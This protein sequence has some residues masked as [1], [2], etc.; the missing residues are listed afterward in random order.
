LFWK[1]SK[2]YS[3]FE[4]ENKPAYWKKGTYDPVENMT[5][6]GIS[7]E[8]RSAKIYFSSYYFLSNGIVE[9]KRTS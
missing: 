7:Y 2:R 5:R 3:I 9:H 1:P 8:T 6:D 4:I